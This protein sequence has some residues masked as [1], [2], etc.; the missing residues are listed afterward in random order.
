MKQTSSTRSVQDEGGA[1]AEMDGIERVGCV[2]VGAG[3]SGLAVAACLKERGFTDVVVL[4]ARPHIE[5]CAVAGRVRVGWDCVRAR[6]VYA[7]ALHEHGLEH[8]L[9]ACV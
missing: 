4:E 6:V 5:V 7:H 1:E 9:A 2:V 3:A 8:G